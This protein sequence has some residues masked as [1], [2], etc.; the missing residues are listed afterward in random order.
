ML[1]SAIERITKVDTPQPCVCALHAT[2][3]PTVTK[4]DNNTRW[5]GEI[6]MRVMLE[7]LYCER[8]R[9]PRV[10]LVVN[11]GP[12]TLQTVRESVMGGCPVVLVSDSGGIATCLADFLKACDS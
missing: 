5:G 4:F 6:P 2:L 3:S 1:P 11:G 10:L 8:R 9:V 7:K 12:G